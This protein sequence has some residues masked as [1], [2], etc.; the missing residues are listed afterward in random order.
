MGVVR[1]PH[2][3]C[4][5]KI[6]VHERYINN[7]QASIKCPGCKQFFKPS[8]LERNCLS[9]SFVSASSLEETQVTPAA[10]VSSG[11]DPVG[12]LVVHSENAPQQ[13]YDLYLG[14]QVVG[15]KS[16]SRECEIMIETRDN[17][18]SRNHFR[19]TVE[20]HGTRYAYLIE[21]THSTNGTFIDTQRFKGYERELKRLSS[22]EQVYLEDGAIIQAGNTKIIL[23][24]L[25]AATS[26]ADATQIVSNL[27]I[28]KTIIL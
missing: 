9:Q 15:R 10:A 2:P 6:N 19:L 23:K 3:G 28:N 1:C 18:I 17:C 12:W 7:P 26:S 27:P 8:L 22:G 4:N 25:G 13:T 16:L 14:V 24:T 21:D 20:R 11:G 5:L